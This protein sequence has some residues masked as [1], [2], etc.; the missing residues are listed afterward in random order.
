MRG[1]YEPCVCARFA[2]AAV[3]NWGTERAGGAGPVIEAVPNRSKTGA[4]VCVLD[5]RQ[6]WEQRA[7]AYS[8]CRTHLMKFK[9]SSNVGCDCSSTTRMMD[10]TAAFQL[11]LMNAI[12]CVSSK[13]TLES[14]RNAE[15]ESISYY[16]ALVIVP[17]WV[18]SHRRT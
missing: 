7:C 5:L 8:R 15:R 16:S 9:S 1:R 13:Y 3:W 12:S 17:W 4:S 11:S 2:V 10:R 18:R 14:L 6:R